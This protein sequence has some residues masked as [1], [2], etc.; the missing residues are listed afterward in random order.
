MRNKIKQ[1]CIRVSALLNTKFKNEEEITKYN[2]VT[3][4]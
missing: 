4:W 3:F 1:Q 2:R